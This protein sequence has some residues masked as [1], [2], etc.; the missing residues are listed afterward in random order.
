MSHEILLR[1][2]KK[3]KKNS[4]QFHEKTK[5]VLKVLASLEIKSQVL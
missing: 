4:S 2:I 5:K 3:K 1:M